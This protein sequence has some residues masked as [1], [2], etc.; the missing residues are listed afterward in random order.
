MTTP[1][2]P[3]IYQKMNDI[4]KELGIVPKGQF[5]T[6]QN[7]AFRGGDDIINKLQPILMRHGVIYM[8]N[9]VNVVREVHPTK[10]GGLMHF[11][12]VEVEH[13]F[14]AIDGSS[15]SCR[16]AGEGG[17]V[18]DKATTKAMSSALKS[19]LE[20]VF[21]I[22]TGEAT[23][24]V[25]A[26]HPAM[27][28]PAAANAPIAQ[29]QTAPPAQ[30][31]PAAPPPSR[32]TDGTTSRAASDKQKRMIYAKAMGAGMD[33]DYFQQL[34][35]AVTGAARDDDYTMDDI[36]NMVK[37]MDAYSAG[38]DVLAAY[39]RRHGGPEPVAPTEAVADDAEATSGANDLPF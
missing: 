18:S 24:G 4:M 32:R 26:Q 8:P 35:V 23:A 22:A 12:I 20:E 9:V 25:T 39:R 3:Q 16:S 1:I 7:Y 19:C 27:Q 5:N 30:A 13:T 15:I 36:D 14:F 10:G 21:C 28:T 29:P 37:A 2:I 33:T 6:E 34:K 17:D 11:S 31:P 38:T